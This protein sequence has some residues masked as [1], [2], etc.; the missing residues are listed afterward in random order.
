MMSF[1]YKNQGCFFGGIPQ[2]C[3]SKRGLINRFLKIEMNVQQQLERSICLITLDS[4]THPTNT[5]C[6]MICFMICWK[7]DNNEVFCNLDR[8]FNMS[9]TWFFCLI[10]DDF[11]RHPGSMM[12]QAPGS[13]AS[14]TFLFI[15]QFAQVNLY[16]NHK[17]GWLDGFIPHCWLRPQIAASCE[18]A[19]NR[20]AGRSFSVALWYNSPT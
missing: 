11:I 14:L 10:G 13:Q 4:M 6:F 20:V 2:R 7:I 17:K 3:F 8:F 15:T 18:P 19:E 5:Y 12:N 9:L 16:M 1:I